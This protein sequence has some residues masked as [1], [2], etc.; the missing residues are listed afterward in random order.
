MLRRVLERPR[1]AEPIRVCVRVLAP[2]V[3]ANSIIPVYANSCATL[4]YHVYLT[5]KKEEALFKPPRRENISFPILYQLNI[6][7]HG[8]DIFY[9]FPGLLSA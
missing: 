1:K 2:R 7:L 9:T 8:D 3:S 4:G 5:S 6:I